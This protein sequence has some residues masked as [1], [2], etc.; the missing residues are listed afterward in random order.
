LWK[1]GKAA[2]KRALLHRGGRSGMNWKTEIVTRINHKTNLQVQMAESRQ[3]Q[4][5]Q[6][7]PEA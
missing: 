5:G 7:L 2:F 3:G 4:V 1:N 6:G